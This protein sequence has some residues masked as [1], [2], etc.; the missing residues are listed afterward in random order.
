MYLLYDGSDDKRAVLA[1]YTKDDFLRKVGEYVLTNDY[2][3]LSVDMVVND[4]DFGLKV[5]NDVKINCLEDELN[6][7]KSRWYSLEKSVNAVMSMIV[8][9]V[10]RAKVKK[11]DCSG[12]ELINKYN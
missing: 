9:E 8:R 7:K 1:A 2:Y 11:P 12:Y 5:V 4:D 6:I 10:I 3:D